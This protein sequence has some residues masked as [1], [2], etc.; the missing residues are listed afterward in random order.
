[1]V[2]QGCIYAWVLVA[3]SH[4]PAMAQQGMTGPDA[5]DA[6]L[7]A[8]AWEA[9]CLTL[10]EC[11]ALE[12]A[13]Q[14]PGMFAL[15]QQ[16]VALL[17]AP[18]RRRDVLDCLRMLPAWQAAFKSGLVV[19]QAPLSR[20]MNWRWDLRPSAGGQPFLEGRLAWT[21]R[22]R[23]RR[24]SG[25]R[26]SF[27][28]GAPAL[29]AAFIMRS[30]AAG[31]LWIGSLV[32]RFGQGLVAWTPSAY[33]DLGG[34]TGSHRIGRGIGPA[35][36]RREGMTMGLGWQ[37]RSGRGRKGRR[38]AMLGR[39]WPQN[40]DVFAM[41][42]EGRHWS[43]ACRMQSRVDR[44]AT[45]VLGLDGRGERGGWSWRVAGAAFPAGWVAR[46]SMLYTLSTHVEGHTVIERTHPGHPESWS[47]NS[48]DAAS[49]MEALPG[50]HW[51]CGLDVTG[52]GNVE[53]WAR[54]MED[55]EGTPPFR[56]QRRSAFRFQSGAHRI[57]VRVRWSEKEAA[58]DGIDGP[59]KGTAWTLALSTRGETGGDGSR[60]WRLHGAVSGQGE[61][62]TFGAAFICSL[63]R[64]NGSTWRWGFGQSWGDEGAPTL[65]VSGWDGRPAEAF[66]RGAFKSY[67]RWKSASGRWQCGVRMAMAPQE[68]DAA[69]DRSVHGIHALRVEFQ[70]FL[71][72]ARKG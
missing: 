51:R 18:E 39:I 50:W 3:V 6:P 34:I 38:W 12:V 8:S 9:G 19:A 61:R 53:G 25:F 32:G 14:D 70:P 15:T 1:M 21:A 35:G 16:G 56:R 55:A 57:D 66:G 20:R 36:Y 23:G 5:P 52:S 65:T 10:E 11:A 4:I 48:D 17:L 47:G 43:W 40:R 72:P 68:P 13:F 64:G 60:T 33:D 37:D 28:E 46:A 24:R 62:R 59:R 26:A 2:R 22:S 71:T 27:S 67:L 44:V 41:G 30:M 69:A 63:K 7:V 29:D 31:D 54:W 49:M 45:I 42:S 58:E